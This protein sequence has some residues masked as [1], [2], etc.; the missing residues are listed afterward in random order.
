MITDMIHRGCQYLIVAC[1][2]FLALAIPAQADPELS[3]SPVTDKPHLRVGL[4]GFSFPPY[5]YITKKTPPQAATEVETTDGRQIDGL[6]IDV[7]DQVAKHADF[8]YEITLFPTYDDVIAAFKA[9]KLD[10]LPGIT[11]TFSRQ[12][13]MAFSDPMFS[14]RRAV[15]TKEKP[16][17]QFQELNGKQIAVEQGFALQELLPN[18]MP[19]ISLF[20]VTD[21]RHAIEAILSAK[22]NGYIG[23]AVVLSHLLRQN[24]D[25]SLELSILPGLPTNH[26]HFA[27]KKGKHKLLSR[28]NFALEDIKNQSLKAIYNQWLNPGQ[29]NM[30]TNYGQ[31]RLSPEERSWL[32]KHPYI[33]VGVHRDWAPYDYLNADKVHSGLTAD[34]LNILGNE[35]GV[36]FQISS[37]KQY[38]EITQAFHDGE[39]MML[40]ALPQTPAQDK[41]MYFS[42]PY[43]HEP[44]VLF[45]P[46]EEGMDTLFS[47]NKL[48]VGIIAD[49]SG[50]E[51]LPH[52]CTDCSSVS[53]I[54]QV[55]AFQALQ[56]EEVDR[57]LTSLH[58]AS[59]LLQSDY[60]GQF[61][62]VGQIEEKNLVPLHFAINFRQPILLNIINKA[63]SSIPPE[64]LIRLENKW[65]TF[66][67]QE[68]LAPKEVAKWAG[69]ITLIALAV[70]ITIICWNRKMAVEMLQRKTAEKRARHA[71]RRLQHLADNLDGVVLQHIQ[72][73]P[74]KP[75]KIHYTFVSAGVK[76]LLGISTTSIKNRP[77][78]LLDLLD[79]ID[80]PELKQSMRQATEL[81]HWDREQKLKY[82]LGQLK[83]VQFKSRI[84]PHEDGGFYWNTV[85]TD[86]SLLKQHQ[87]ALEYARQKAE[88]ATAAKSQF[89]ATISHEVRT[90]ISGILGLLELMA[91]QP[92]NEELINLHGGLTQSA[93][94]M[95]HIVN[96]VLDYSK[97]EAGKLELT[98]TNIDLGSVLARIIQ[99]QSIHA[100]QKNLAFQYWQDPALADW[101]FADDIRLHQILN[102]FLNNAIKFTE[103]GTIGLNVD[104][105]KEH[106]SDRQPR[107]QTI[108]FTIS[109][110]G[111]GISP[112]QQETLFKPFEQADNST[113][114]RFGGTG[115]G[116]AIARK[117]IE[118]MHGTISLNSQLGKGSEF[119]VTVTL[120][121]GE[122]DPELALSHQP[123]MTEIPPA[124]LIG[125]SLVIGYFIQREA[126]C[127]YLQHLGLEPSML[128]ID[129]LQQLKN[130][131][132]KRQP[133]HI[134]IAMAIWQQLQLCDQWLKE[135]LPNTKVIIINQNPM[136]S[137]EPIGQ[138][139]CLSVNPLLPDNLKHVL[140]KPVSEIQTDLIDHVVA[141]SMTESRR[142]AEEHGRL[143][144]VAEDH[145]INQQVISKQL[146]KIGIHADIVE[147]GVLALEAMKHHRYG[148]LLTD[149]HMPEMDGYTLSATIRQQER[150]ASEAEHRNNLT[151]KALNSQFGPTLTHSYQQKHTAKTVK[152][153]PATGLPIIALTANAIQGEDNHCYEMGMSDFLVKPVSIAKLQQVLWSW[154]NIDKTAQAEPEHKDEQG[155]QENSANEFLD[156]FSAIEEQLSN[157]T[158]PE[159]PER[160][161][162]QEVP[163]K[164]DPPSVLDKQKILLLFEDKDV[165]NNLVAEFKQNHQQDFKRLKQAIN[166]DNQEQI[167]TIAHRMKGASQMLECD[168]LAE[169]LETIEREAGQ[170]QFSS[171][172]VAYASLQSLTSQL[173]E[174]STESSTS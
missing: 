107:Q 82:H 141:D 11:S 159:R 144:L 39:L 132:N 124:P 71:E 64:E 53:Y 85:V 95:L 69:V 96:D 119:S 153:S 56:K 4:P 143:I 60:L 157:D 133:S 35:L 37:K 113:S 5:T 47:N 68:G 98:P 62:M 152:G 12:Q 49:T 43:I 76:E 150:R 18:L 128:A 33:T 52:I 31:L 167:Y 120:P 57:V 44:W 121:L 23:D 174:E 149:C 75:L 111:V 21:S 8:T 116:L 2:L 80:I 118:Q 105:L 104:V 137:P 162:P 45:A 65:L 173:L 170:G 48:K 138:Q 135:H 108:R 101:Y 67:Y 17:N 61:K 87:L 36:K 154:L 86:I 139:W 77:E 19:N 29:I 74:E 117:L 72:P 9:N 15:I 42:A 6:L 164:R 136:L 63:I 38:S 151:S 41:L 10:L 88:T 100:Q 97:I 40:S 127:R 1:C 165:V 3:R 30:F 160:T 93:K 73:D 130:E 84:T 140:T 24:N 163:E 46:A 171:D 58:H 25:P 16:I 169:P 94:N 147:N 78:L 70:I 115:L 123:G 106:D 32:D 156:L 79:N 161:L 155:L 112:E 134:F 148:L 110:T 145:P 26:L 51:L 102:N 50:S 109:D 90:P 20:S 22:A 166:E 131:A 92:L 7:L 34:L 55:S 54:N 168:V 125:N 122:P 28:I 59:P 142:S 14:I 126:L 89:L 103:Q 99:P 172:C 83:W 114:R 91:D 13:Y 158:A 129:H 81:G 27:I 146:K 66:E